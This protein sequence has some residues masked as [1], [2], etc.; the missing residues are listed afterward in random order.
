MVFIDP[1]TKEFVLREKYLSGNIK[2]KLLQ[3]T[4]SA[5]LDKKF[6]KNVNALKAILPKDVSFYDI[7]LKLGA[8]YIPQEILQEFIAEK[9]NINVNDVYIYYNQLSHSYRNNFV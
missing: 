8:P 4:A 3:A 2:E 1:I 9:L 7:N 5:K 6:T